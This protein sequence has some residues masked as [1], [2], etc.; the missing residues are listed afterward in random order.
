MFIFSVANADFSIAL[1]L[2]SLDDDWNFEVL[3]FEDLILTSLLTSLLKLTFSAWWIGL[4]FPH[5]CCSSFSMIYC[6]LPNSFLRRII[7]S[8]TNKSFENKCFLETSF[9]LWVGILDVTGIGAAPGCCFFQLAWS[10][11]WM[12]IYLENWVISF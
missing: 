5:I 9:T 11:W 7:S 1:S 3:S 4:T 2:I 10:C 8:C 6:L 12:I